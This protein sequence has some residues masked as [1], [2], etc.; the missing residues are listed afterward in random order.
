[1]KCAIR[2][3]LHRLTYKCFENTVVE[4]LQKGEVGHAELHRSTENV[5][6]V[7]MGQNT[8]A[9]T[10]A[11]IPPGKSSARAGLKSISNLD[12]TL[13]SSM[14]KVTIWT[15]SKI[16]IFLTF[17]RIPQP[18]SGKPHSGLILHAQ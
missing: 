18:G 2:F 17:A 7:K 8:S 6:P 3:L 4:V 10:R 14:A 11:E 15:T 1:M 16:L 5:A 9:L 12:K 13:L